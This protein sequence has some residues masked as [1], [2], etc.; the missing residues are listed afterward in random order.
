M[1]C[2]ILEIEQGLWR[3]RRD[4]EERLCLYCNTVTI[5]TEIHPLLQ[6]P[7]HNN[8]QIKLYE[9]IQSKNIKE[10]LESENEEQRLLP[11]VTNVDTF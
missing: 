1:S 5:E 3:R 4:R 11:I 7:K 9:V 2:H 6:Y 8:D 10:I